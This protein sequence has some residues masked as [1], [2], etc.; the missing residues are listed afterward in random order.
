[1]REQ[2]PAPEVQDAVSSRADGLA[3]DIRSLVDDIE[4]LDMLQQRAG[5][6]TILA[7]AKVYKGYRLDLALPPCDRR[8]PPS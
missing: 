2:T 3:G 7:E 1:M 8:R 4:S 6:Q 5:L